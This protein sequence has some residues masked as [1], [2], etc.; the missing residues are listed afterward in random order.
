MSKID[1]LIRM[2]DE[3]VHSDP[4]IIII[5]SVKKGKW[6]LRSIDK[7]KQEYYKTID[8]AITAAR[9]HKRSIIVIDDIGEDWEDTEEALK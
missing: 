6:E 3:K 9:K 2:Y 4:G 8:E 7:N 1:E 5:S